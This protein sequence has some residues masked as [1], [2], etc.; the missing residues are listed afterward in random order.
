MANTTGLSKVISTSFLAGQ[1]NKRLANDRVDDPKD[2]ELINTN[3][4]KNKRKYSD[5][6]DQS[7]NKSNYS[8]EIISQYFHTNSSIKVNV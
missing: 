7:I 5:S 6:P 8:N 4:G 2:Q 1:A 3:P